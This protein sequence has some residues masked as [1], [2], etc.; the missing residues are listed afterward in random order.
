[1]VQSGPEKTVSPGRMGD[2]DPSLFGLRRS[3]LLEMLK[4]AGII[5]V[6]VF[7][8]SSLYALACLPPAELEH[9]SIRQPVDIA[10]PPSP[11]PSE[12]EEVTSADT[13][14]LS[15]PI[16]PGIARP[17]RLDQSAHPR[18]VLL[19]IETRV[20]R[21]AEILPDRYPGKIR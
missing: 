13:S 14:S 8:V 2:P 7:S 12:S 17:S 20:E 9:G 15:V 21:L 10:A 1:M 11:V 16:L 5:L 4:H 6:V 18:R 19:G 3:E